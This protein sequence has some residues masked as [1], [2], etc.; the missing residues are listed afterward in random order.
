[1]PQG[2][3]EKNCNVPRISAGPDVHQV[4]LGSEGTLGIITEVILKVQPPPACKRYGAVVLPS[5]EA[6]VKCR[7]KND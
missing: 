7:R 1:M 3:I 4:I 5:F 6:G 2:V